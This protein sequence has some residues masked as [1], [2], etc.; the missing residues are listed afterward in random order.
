MNGVERRSPDSTD[1][2]EMAERLVDS[3]V[4][5]ALAGSAERSKDQ[6][7]AA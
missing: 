6:Q 4:V 2:A 5:P 1:L 7:E 3:A